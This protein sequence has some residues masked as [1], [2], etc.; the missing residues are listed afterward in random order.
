MME[1]GLNMYNWYREYDYKSFEIFHN[2][3]FRLLIFK[4]AELFNHSEGPINAVVEE[5]IITPPWVYEI[6]EAIMEIITLMYNFFNV[7]HKLSKNPSIKARFST[8][9]SLLKV[10]NEYCKYFFTMSIEFRVNRVLACSL[11]LNRFLECILEDLKEL[12][13]HMDQTLVDNLDEVYLFMQQRIR[14][15]LEVT[16]SQKDHEINIVL[17]DMMFLL[18]RN[19]GDP[20]MKGILDK[21]KEREIIDSILK[22]NEIYD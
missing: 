7:E 19:A 14:E 17:L 20:I 2:A 22:S 18:L 8:I 3:K 4:A 6:S 16:R 13:K 1:T 21:G 9:C 12:R 11:R 10:E 15:A 5:D